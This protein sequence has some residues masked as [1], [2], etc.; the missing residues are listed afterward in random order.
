MASELQILDGNHQR[1][2]PGGLFAPLTV[3]LS[4]GGA[5]VA[6]APVAF[7]INALGGT[8]S[9]FPEGDLVAAVLTKPDGIA[10]APALTAG[11]TPGK[12]TVAAAG[13]GAFASFTVWVADG[14][15][16][17]GHAPGLASQEVNRSVR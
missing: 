1:A 7:A 9:G 13:D 8:G 10:S 12:V 15:L 2:A 16:L 6:A 17:S 14:Q 4:T 11:P 3:R 5:P